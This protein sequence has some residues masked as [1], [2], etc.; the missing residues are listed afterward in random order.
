M[1][2]E[3][4][5]RILREAEPNSWIA[6]ASDESRVVAIAPTYADAVAAAEREG[7][8]DPVLLKTPD[9]WLPLVL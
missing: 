4:R 8:E 2:D 5:V 7:V 3:E 6:L 9:E 1:S